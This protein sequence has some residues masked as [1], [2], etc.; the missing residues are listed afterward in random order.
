MPAVANRDTLQ[1]QIKAIQEEGNANRQQMA[2]LFE[3]GLDQIAQGQVQLGGQITEL[4]GD[5]LQL[6]G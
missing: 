5:I 1:Q 2:A 3:Q 6:Q 4:R